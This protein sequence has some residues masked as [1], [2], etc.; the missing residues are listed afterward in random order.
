MAPT[1]PP[2]S[3][4]QLESRCKI[5]A[6]TTHGLTGSE[7]ERLLAQVKIRNT[8]PGMTKWKHPC[9]ALATRQNG[10][11][12]ADRV[13]AFVRLAVDPARYAGAHDVFEDRRTAINT[14]LA[15]CGYEYGRTVGSVWWMPRRH[16]R[17]R[18]SAPI[19]CGPRSP[20]GAF[21]PT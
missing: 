14:V 19:A 17:R 4:G 15:L 11:G 5:L 9:S 7:I 12:S 2:L 16:S 13:F 10:D 3:S 6:D 18:R 20:R 21:T 8:E 1:P